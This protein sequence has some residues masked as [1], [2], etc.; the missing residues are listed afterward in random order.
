M[1]MNEWFK[2]LVEQIRALPR[3]R[4]LVLLA[5]ALGSIGFL[6]WITGGLAEPDYRPL[7]RGLEP[8]EAARVTD[9]LRVLNIAYRLDAGGT[10][11][12]VPAGDVH[13]ARI[14]VAG[15]GLPSGS[16]TGFELFDRPAFGVTDFVHEVNYS[17][18][19][20]G[21]LARSIEQLDAVERA[22]VQVVIPKK[23]GGVLAATKRKASASVLVRLAPGRQLTGDQAQAIVHL[24][25]SSIEALDPSQVTVVDGSGRLL[26]PSQDQTPGSRAPGGVLAHQARVESDL[27]ERIEA[28]LEPVV[29]FGGV[30]ARVS[31]EMDWTE[32]EVTEEVFD[33]DSQIA[34]SESRTEESENTG[35]EGG[36]PGVAAN[37]PGGAGEGASGVGS[38]RS[39]ET[40]NYELSKTVS[41]HVTA[42]GT[43]K[44]LSVAVLVDGSQPEA[45]ADGEVVPD[46]ETPRW[47]P[48]DIERFEQLAMQAVGYSKKRGDQIVVSSAPF[49]T[50]EVVEGEGGF[51]M[52]PRLLTHGSQALRILAQLLALVLFAR[53]IVKPSLD[54][55]SDTAAKTGEAALPA[56]VA[57][58]EA[59][60]DGGS[61]E[62][63][64]PALPQTLAEKVGLE[65][66]ARSED[67]VTT[68]RNW[69]N[70]E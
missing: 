51:A 13:E 62:M 18:A 33:P 6:W 46:E 10:T 55:V 47:T 34:R 2:N 38:S 30:V 40:L 19:V 41:H 21:E 5:T 57:S 16:A 70:Q 23:G 56:S 54:V 63:A 25:A 44:R 15:K 7:Y 8:E 52:D 22:R 24:V 14:R 50:P 65:A 48:E 20:Q 32:S 29:G 26:A 9:A 69:L 35:G 36:A 45:V 43:I 53:F 60:L 64:L 4:Q 68:I 11:V 27:A 67:S 66:G 39:T 17:R 49:Q 12:E 59:A 28:I 42:M 37:V 31:A 1:T 61:P 3:E 58:L